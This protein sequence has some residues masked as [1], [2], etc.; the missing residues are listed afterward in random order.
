MNSS[1]KIFLFLFHSHQMPLFDEKSLSE[2]HYTFKNVFN[3]FGQQTKRKQRTT[4]SVCR[5]GRYD[6]LMIHET[7]L[8]PHVLVLVCRNFWIIFLSE[9]ID[10]LTGNDECCSDI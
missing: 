8:H 3:N 4:R 5:F 7:P 6:S 1:L 2:K 9:A 10:V